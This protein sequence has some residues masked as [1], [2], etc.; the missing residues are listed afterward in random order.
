MCHILKNDGTF[1]ISGKF[2]HSNTRILSFLIIFYL[3]FNDFYNF[4][5]RNTGCKFTTKTEKHG[6]A[7]D[8]LY[9]AHHQNNPWWC[10]DRREGSAWWH[11]WLSCMYNVVKLPPISM[12]LDEMEP[13]KREINLRLCEWFFFKK[14]QKPAVNYHLVGKTNWSSRLV[15]LPVLSKFEPVKHKIAEYIAKCLCLPFLKILH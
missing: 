6:A 11:K 12:P 9:A 3:F 13:T 2:K 14:T 7:S 5:T 1:N 10:C 8:Y 4:Y 15:V